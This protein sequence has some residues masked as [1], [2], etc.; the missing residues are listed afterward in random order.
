M[1]SKD[2]VWNELWDFKVKESIKD[3]DESEQ[4]EISCEEESSEEEESEDE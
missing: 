2:V 4:S 3:D 1:Q